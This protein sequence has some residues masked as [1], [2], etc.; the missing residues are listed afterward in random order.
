MF[1][2]LHLPMSTTALNHSQLTD[3]NAFHE[4][5]AKSRYPFRAAIKR[6]HGQYYMLALDF[7]VAGAGRT[8]RDAQHDLTRLLR[9]YLQSYFREGRPLEDAVRPVGWRTRIAIALGTLAWKG[10]DSAPHECSDCGDDLPEALLN[11][12]A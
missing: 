8:R 1:P 5:L 10:L 4:W 2:G 7:N 9:A 11:Q 6:K 12:A 3:E